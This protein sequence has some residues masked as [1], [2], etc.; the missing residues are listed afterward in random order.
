[1]QV[2]NKIIL[3]KTIEI[4]DNEINK[5]EF[6]KKGARGDSDYALLSNCEGAFVA[7]TSIRAYLLNN[8]DNV[9]Y[10]LEEILL[11]RIPEMIKYQKENGDFSNGYFTMGYVSALRTLIFKIKKL[12]EQFR[13]KNETGYNLHYA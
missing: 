11:K 9:L 3:N 6:L 5:I 12:Y 1:M 8:T 13:S 7:Y 2:E 10:A 4:V